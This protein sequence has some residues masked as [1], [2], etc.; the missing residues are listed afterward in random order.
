MSGTPELLYGQRAAASV[1]VNPAALDTAATETVVIENAEIL[2]VLYEVPM[3]AALAAL[4]VALHPSIP[5]I[6]GMTRWLPPV[7]RWFMDRLTPPLA[8]H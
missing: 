1:A 7:T 5:A 2:Y 8:G 3:Q 6:Y 4:P